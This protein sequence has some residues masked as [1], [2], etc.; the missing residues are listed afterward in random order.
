[1]CTISGTHTK[2]ASSSGTAVSRV[3]GAWVT[4]DFLG[5]SPGISSDTHGE[6]INSSILF[7]Q[8]FLRVFD[9]CNGSDLLNN[10]FP[11]L[12][13]MNLRVRKNQNFGGILL[14]VLSLGIKM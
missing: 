7:K 11:W 14:A 3:E 6:R 1:M 2:A 5:Q 10:A 9:S 4:S 12:G 8:L 13:A